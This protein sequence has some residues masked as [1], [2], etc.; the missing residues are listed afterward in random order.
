LS[1]I[2]SHS[3]VWIP[4]RTSSLRAYFVLGNIRLYEAK[5]SGSLRFC[6]SR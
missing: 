3:P 2:I 4:A 5:C 1:P 6:N